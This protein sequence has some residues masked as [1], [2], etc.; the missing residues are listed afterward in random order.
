MPALKPLNQAARQRPRSARCSSIVPT[1]GKL[2]PGAWSSQARSD[3]QASRIPAASSQMASNCLAADSW[4]QQAWQRPASG[5]GLDAQRGAADSFRWTGRSYRRS[6]KRHADR[7][8]NWLRTMHNGLHR[9]HPGN[10]HSGNRCPFGRPHQRPLEPRVAWAFLALG[11]VRVSCARV[12]YREPLF[13]Y[14]KWTWLARRKRSRATKKPARLFLHATAM[15][16]GRGL[17]C[18]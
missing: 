4:V 16:F 13:C 15:A 3:D 2:L 8:C 12:G 7:G 6:R 11:W 17:R 5:S 10:A 9:M 14:R 1:P 18:P